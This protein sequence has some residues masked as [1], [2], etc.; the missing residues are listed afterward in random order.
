MRANAG[1]QLRRAMSIQ[2]EG[3][4]LLEKTCY[5]AVSCKGF[6]VPAL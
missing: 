4:K 1:L 5:R 3:K 2:V 6:V